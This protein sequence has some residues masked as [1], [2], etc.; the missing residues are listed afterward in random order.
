[1]SNIALEERVNWIGGTDVPALL[2]KSPHKTL[3][4][5][6]HIKAGNI[7]GDGTLGDRGEAGKFMESAIAA[8]AAD[9]WSL[10]L[11]KV[12]RHIPHK[13]I[14]RF[15]VSLDY[16]TVEGLIPYEIKNVDNLVFRDNWEHEGDVITRTPLEYLLQCQAQLACTGKPRHGLV[17]LVGGNSLYRMEIGR[18]ER[19]I[20]KIE[21]AVQQFWIS[22]EDDKPP[23]PD[24]AADAAAIAELYRHT[25]QGFAN[26]SSNNRLNC[27]LA[28]YEDARAREKSA[29]Q[30]KEAAKAEVLTIINGHSKVRCGD[31]VLNTST[32]REAEISYTRKPYRA[33]RLDRTDEEDLT[34][35]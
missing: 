28:N 25:D 30:E 22:I 7:S 20:A 3:F 5:V 14:G 10:R 11:R 33:F 35:A 31:F 8:W 27:V 23:K 12:R 19:V 21:N 16:E 26:L 15:G 34:D 1:M 17:A 9:K 13:S 2:G 6:W 32:V 18:H 29:G 24:F 4:E